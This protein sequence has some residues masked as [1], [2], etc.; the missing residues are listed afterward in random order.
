MGF[1]A[2]YIG[3]PEPFNDRDHSRFRR[4]FRRRTAPLTAAA[5]LPF[6]GKSCRRLRRGIA[7]PRIR[8]APEGFAIT[9]N[10]KKPAY[11]GFSPSNQPVSELAAEKRG[12]G[13]SWLDTLH[14]IE[15]LQV[16][17]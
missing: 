8:P 11:A 3:L 6:V 17:Q 9:A 10:E 7:A 1:P 5:V 13:R 4:Q 12:G 2:E 16:D 15:R 14:H